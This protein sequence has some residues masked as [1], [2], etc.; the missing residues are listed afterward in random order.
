MSSMKDVSFAE[1][2][3]KMTS[4]I[5]SST[6]DLHS[7]QTHETQSLE[8]AYLAYLQ[9]TMGR[10]IPE[11]STHNHLASAY[12]KYQKTKPQKTSTKFFLKSEGMTVRQFKAYEFLLYALE[13]P[14]LKAH[15]LFP[16]SF[17][18]VQLKKAYKLAAL[19]NHP[20]QGG[21]HESFLELRKCYDILEGFVKTKPS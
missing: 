19:K 15:Q 21:S 2:L 14:I 6:A 4:E 3:E 12:F 18:L 1:I 8:P 17:N 20:D 10:S 11:L 13:L 9:G 7:S 5:D 16:E